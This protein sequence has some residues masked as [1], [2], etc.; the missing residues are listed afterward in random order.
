[1]AHGVAKGPALGAAL[2]K[3]EEAWIGADFPAEESEIAQIAR[4]AAKGLT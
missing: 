2:R 1:M 4:M 3:A